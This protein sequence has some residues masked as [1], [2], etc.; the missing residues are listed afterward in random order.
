[1]TIFFVLW[2]VLGLI[3]LYLILSMENKDNGTN[4]TVKSPSIIFAA[5]LGAILFVLA[6]VVAV[7]RAVT[8][9]EEK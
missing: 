8:K 1:M 4:T 9:D 5:G 6:I 7:V 2:Y 3:G